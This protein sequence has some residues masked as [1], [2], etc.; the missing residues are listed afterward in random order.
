[1]NFFE[2]LVT[3]LC[4]N[5]TGKCTTEV[6]SALQDIGLTFSSKLVLLFASMWPFSLFYVI[7]SQVNDSLGLIV[8]LFFIVLIY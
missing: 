1:M 7:F 5:Y 2:S 4:R 6:A 8:R 3:L